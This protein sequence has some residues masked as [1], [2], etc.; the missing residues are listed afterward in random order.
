[1]AGNTGIGDGFQCSW[2]RLQLILFGQ[3]IH[4]ERTRSQFLG[5]GDKGGFFI[6][7]EIE[8]GHGLQDG[9]LQPLGMTVDSNETLGQHLESSLKRYQPQVQRNIV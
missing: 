6:R 1:M 4:V 3:F 7:F 9:L 8:T 5:Q 2:N